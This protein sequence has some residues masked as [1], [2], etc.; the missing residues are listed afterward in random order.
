MHERDLQRATIK[1]L[2]NC[3]L[4]YI[5]VHADGWCETG[6]PDLVTC[7]DGKFIAF[8]LKTITGKTTPA[9]IIHQNNIVSNKGLYF[10]VRSIQE[11]K[12]IVSKLRGACD[13]KL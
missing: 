7:I 2:Q 3:K 8:E 9:Q 4:Y 11:F 10:I 6:A 12:D 1:H 13:E 5:K